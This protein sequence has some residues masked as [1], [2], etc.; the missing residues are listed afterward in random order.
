MQTPPIITTTALIALFVVG[1][2]K[3]PSEPAE[4]ATNDRPV[5]YVPKVDFG[6][7]EFVPQTPKRVSIAGGRECLMFVTVQ[8][9]GNLQIELLMDVKSADGKTNRLGQ[10]RLIARAGQEC[11]L[12]VGDT[13]VSLTPTL[14]KQ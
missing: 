3:S 2:S 10:S 12:S 8:S 5:S 14:K 4:Q 7:V 1:C 11:A 6:V 13:M 9:D